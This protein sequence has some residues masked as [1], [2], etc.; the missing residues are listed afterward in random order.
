MKLWPHPSLQIGTTCKSR[1]RFFRSRYHQLSPDDFGFTR[2]DCEKFRF[3]CRGPTQMNSCSCENRCNHDR[4]FRARPSIFA[5]TQ[6]NRLNSQLH[7]PPGHEYFF[8]YV[9]STR[10]GQSKR[11]DSIMSLIIV[12]AI[13]AI[14]MIRR[15]QGFAKWLRDTHNRPTSITDGSND[16][17][18]SPDG[19]P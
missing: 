15:N 2:I 14:S 17:M 7:M 6:T 10:G 13:L 11:T 16:R 19:L 4:K 5:R 18:N 8:G 9:E 3:A 1:N 12:S